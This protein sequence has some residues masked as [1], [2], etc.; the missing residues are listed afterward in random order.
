MSNKKQNDSTKELVITNEKIIGFYNKNKQIDFEKVN[1]LYINLFENI[2]SA[3]FE[4]PA[5]VNHIM[6]SLNNQNNDLNNIL[7]VVKQSSETYKNELSNMREL[8]SL[9]VNNI[10][11]DIELIKSTLNSTITNKIHESK[12]Y[13]IKELKEIFQFK[14]HQTINNLNL[15]IEKQNNSLTD[16]LVLVLNDIIPK[17]QSKQY[18]DII[19][20]FK[21]DMITS[22]KS[23]GE[24][25]NQ[26]PNIVIDKISNI[27]EIKYNTLISNIH[28][29]MSNYIAQSEIRLTN[30][31]NQLKEVSTKNT[32][33]QEN[34]S[35]ELF[36]YINKTKNISQK[37]AQSE[38]ILFNLLNKEYS[39]ADIINTSGQ[40][41]QGDIII[42]RK[43]KTPI[44]IETKNYSTN[45][46][47]EEVDKFLRDVSNKDCH[48]IFL[49]QT[50]GI[51]GKDNFQIDI[52]NKNILIYIHN[53]DYDIAK[54][55]LAINTIDLLFDKLININD[56][57]VTISNDILKNINTE[58]HN[59]VLQREKLLN[60]LKEYYKKTLEQYTDLI[61]P[62]L[63]KFI[64]I[65]Y[66]NIKKNI[67]TCDICKK[68]E[69]ANL[70][71]LARHK[72]SCKNKHLCV[73][74]EESSNSESS[75]SLKLSNSPKSP[76]ISTLKKIK[77][78][79][80]VL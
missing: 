23:I 62:S 21:N 35:D 1:L 63:E 67:L 57:N 29:N 56:K 39:S 58:Y 33:I 7:S 51:V 15:V 31:L 32:I 4:N 55:N 53:V 17:S 22:I 6:M 3:S 64:S 27:V 40:T 38:N 75:T 71:S 24:I 60:G 69:S 37:G 72:Q 80:I 54:I 74:S 11:G 25:K 10:K 9:S 49:S 13:Y 19:N 59:F 52:H 50:S 14:E 47:K 34:I 43:D 20:V 42:K 45:V 79:D 66:A 77:N 78:K 65:H 16:K 73:L 46:K 70:R 26:D 12:D 18:D 44:L 36:S 2:M 68:Y 5:I 8:Y 61:L 28:E 48:G 41:G 30:N 76:K